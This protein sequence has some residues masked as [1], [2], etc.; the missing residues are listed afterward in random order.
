MKKYGVLSIGMLIA[1]MVLLP[2][3]VQAKS[4]HYVNYDYTGYGFSRVV[5]DRATYG[6]TGIFDAVVYDESG[7]AL[8]DGQWFEGL[9]V[10]PGSPIHTGDWLASSVSADEFKGNMGLKAAWL[11]DTFFYDQPISNREIAGLQLAIWEVVKDTAYNLASGNFRVTGGDGTAREL[12]CMYLAELQ[13]NFNTADTTRLSQEYEVFVDANKQDLLFKTSAV[14]EPSTLLL[15][16]VGML[17]LPGLR[18]KM[19]NA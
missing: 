17:G 18:R 15:L 1:V 5:D 9:C 19:K 2:L 7:Q 10:E 4:L 8:E 12:A 11:A 6:N 3:T 16:G 14:P 13:E